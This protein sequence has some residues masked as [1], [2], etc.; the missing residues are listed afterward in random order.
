M[1][2]GLLRVSIRLCHRLTLMHQRGVRLAIRRLRCRQLRLQ[3]GPFLL[4]LRSG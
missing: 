4:T 3:F 2:G 1:E